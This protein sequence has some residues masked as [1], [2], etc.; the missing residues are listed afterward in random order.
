MCSYYRRRYRKNSLRYPGRDYSRTGKYFVT[1]CIDRMQKRFGK[2]IN[3]EMQLSELG[4]IALNLWREIPLHFA[5]TVLDEFVVMPNHIHGII[6]IDNVGTLHATSL[7]KPATSLPKPAT[8]LPKPA[9]TLPT[10]NA[11]MSSISPK[12]GSLSVIIRSYKS[13]V[14]K[15]AH[16]I[17]SGFSWQRS[18]YDT[19]ICTPAQ[20]SRIR[21][22]IVDNPIKWENKT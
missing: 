18:F 6:I 3:G 10:K 11:I 4:R 9:T 8:S 16:K 21:K 1:I 13:A 12:S 19:I 22:Y 17:D 20:L 15:N 5:N 14:S 2:V 7:P